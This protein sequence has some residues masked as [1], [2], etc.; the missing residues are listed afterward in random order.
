M[1]T[2]F[3]YSN[4]K[5]FKKVRRFY[6]ARFER[7]EL[8]SKKWNILVFFSGLPNIAKDFGS[9]KLR[10]LIRGTY[11]ISKKK[12]YITLVSTLP[13][14]FGKYLATRRNEPLFE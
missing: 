7:E 1:G 6:F 5:Q 8:Q 14:F 4:G 3:S 10:F 11:S 12:V 13:S 2:T 9:Q